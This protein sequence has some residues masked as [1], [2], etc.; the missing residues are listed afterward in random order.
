MIS[1]KMIQVLKTIRQ[2]EKRNGVCKAREIDVYVDR[3]TLYRSLNR[4]E[5]IDAVQSHE[6]PSNHKIQK[7]YTLTGFGAKLTEKAEKVQNR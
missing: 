1:W 3:S 7:T 2:R 5:E 4:L 6:A